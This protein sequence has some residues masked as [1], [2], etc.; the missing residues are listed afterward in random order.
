[1]SEITAKF[2]AAVDELI[3]DGPIKQRLARAFDTNL[4]DLA[5]I[6]LPPDAG[7]AFRGLQEAMHAVAPIG[8]GS[9]IQSSVQKMSPVEAVAHAR[10]IVE[11]YRKLLLSARRADHLK[12]I[13]SPQERADEPPPQFL[14]GAT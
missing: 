5:A 10:T 6:H 13:E 2:E 4:D 1:M 3:G 14:V 11:L 12:V 9:R 7:D 8:R